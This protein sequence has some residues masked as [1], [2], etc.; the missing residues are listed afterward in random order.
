MSKGHLI[1]AGDLFLSVPSIGV[2]F[3]RNEKAIMES[4]TEYCIELGENFPL[5]VFTFELW[6]DYH[7]ENIMCLN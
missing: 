7:F 5:K 2:F 3:C 1:Y 6:V 4:Y